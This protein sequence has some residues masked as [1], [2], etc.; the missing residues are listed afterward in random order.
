[1]PSYKLSYFNARG[2]GEIARMVLAAAGQKFEDVRIN[3]DDWPTV[4]PS[5]IVLIIYILLL[6]YYSILL[7]Y[8]FIFFFLYY[9]CLQS[10]NIAKYLSREARKPV[11]RVS[12]QVL[13]Q[14]ACT[15]NKCADEL[16]SYAF[17]FAYASLVF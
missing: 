3:F 10:I 2:R 1:M 7:F 6:L 14:L 16:C 12:D 13:H 8:L 4:K 17:V 5:K 11:F 9:D 15:S